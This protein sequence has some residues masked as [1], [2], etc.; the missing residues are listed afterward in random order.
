M[1]TDSNMWIFNFG[2]SLIENDFKWNFINPEIDIIPTNIKEI[3][4]NL[5]GCKL[6]F[7]VRFPYNGNKYSSVNKY[8]I[9]M[10]S[11]NKLIAKVN[12][13]ELKII[14]KNT[15]I[16]QLIEN[17]KKHALHF[18]FRDIKQIYVPRTIHDS[19]KWNED[20]IRINISTIIKKYK[21]EKELKL[22]CKLQH[23]TCNDL[24]NMI[25][26]YL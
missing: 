12:M 5:F 1:N 4:E 9:C 2:K 10:F 15:S 13:Y 7:V 25:V 14:D 17:N 11:K 6:E 20:I 24:T 8:T 26:S 21:D 22:I 3:L 19:V 16:T 18:N 23:I